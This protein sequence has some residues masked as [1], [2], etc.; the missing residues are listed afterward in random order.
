M[1]VETTT[2]QSVLTE[3][4][5]S[6]IRADF[7]ILSKPV[8][9]KQ[10]AFLDSAASSQK[11]QQVIDVIRRF[12]EE[13]NANIHRGVYYLSEIATQQYEDA[14]E[15]VRR[16]INASSIKEV[17]FTAGTTDAFN[18]VASS[19]GRTFLQEGD[20]I[21][22]STMEH[23]ANIVP[24]QL[25]AEERGVVLREVPITDDGELDIASYHEMLNEKTRLVSLVYASNSLGT[26]NPVRDIIAAAK[27]REIPV[28]LD[29][30]QAIV[31]MPINVQELDCDFLAFSGHKIYGPT[32]IGVLYGR[33]ALLNEMK[34]YRGGGDMIRTV[35]IE[36]STYNEL[37]GKFEAGTPNIVGAIGLAAALDYVSKIGMSRIAGWENSLLEYGTNR[38][39]EV[40]GLRMVGTAS[41][42]VGVMSF[43]LD[44][45]HPH[46]I[47]TFL[48]QE[49]VAV[50]TGHH[51]T[52]P[53][54]TRYG[55][56]AT[57]RASLGVYN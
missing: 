6:A 45:V 15:T 50:R 11:P 13:E 54:M 4:E 10:L 3:S 53:I 2:I 27:A 9:G 41:N 33:E 24:W 16:F 5:V 14:R 43:V 34:P 44:N 37:P 21:I 57:T 35:S 47:G 12:Y 20:E 42:K 32:G 22:L 40:P 29:A 30:A 56:P 46:D 19:F 1:S 36:K 49:G 55:L 23:H 48:D 26:I 25:M 51:C 18:L 31:H 8:R 17:I 38:L 28:M 52:Q 39:A 7:P